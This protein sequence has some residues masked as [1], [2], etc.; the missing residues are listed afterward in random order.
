M[1]TGEG[2]LHGSGHITPVS[3]SGGH[4]KKV[5]TEPGVSKF[6]LW[7][8]LNYQGTSARARRQQFWAYRPHAFIF[9]FVFNF[10]DVIL[11]FL[12]DGA[13]PLWTALAPDK[14]P[15]KYLLLL[16]YVQ[17]YMLAPIWEGLLHSVFTQEPLTISPCPQLA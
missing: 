10:Q 3:T 14:K 5:S 15:Y 7:R 2:H 8:T 9:I 4:E 6:G 1:S 13:V 16:P 11:L 17:E 12:P